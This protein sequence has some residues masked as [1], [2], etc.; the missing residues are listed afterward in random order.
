MSILQLHQ[1]VNN[2][3]DDVIKIMQ[4]D[5]LQETPGSAFPTG[6]V[7]PTSEEIE[8][9]MHRAAAVR[10]S[11]SANIVP[12][13]LARNRLNGREPSIDGRWLSFHEGI[14]D[15]CQQLLREI[16]GEGLSNM[17]RDDVFG[18][19]VRANYLKA[20][21]SEANEATGMAAVDAVH[22]PDFRSVRWFGELYSFTFNESVVVQV[23]WTAWEQGT[24]DVSHCTLR[25][26]IEELEKSSLPQSRERIG[27]RAK[28]KNVFRSKG[29]KKAWGTLV[30][31]GETRGTYRLAEPKKLTVI[32]KC[33][34]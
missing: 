27:D 5:A 22:S 3:Y 34:P 26:A 14:V 25:E 18:E 20:L 32:P 7:A 16:S 10:Q 13:R 33:T 6:V 1:E 31:A 15:R 24:P 11:L 9:L 29:G 8:A 12:F 23:L 4:Q 21:T 19:T 2:L 28:L 17:P 30:V